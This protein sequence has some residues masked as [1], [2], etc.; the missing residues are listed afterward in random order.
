MSV[1]IN[2]V[3][4]SGS[5]LSMRWNGGRRMALVKTLLGIG[6]VLAAGLALTACGE[7]AQQATSGGEP[8]RAQVVTAERAERPSAVELQ[9]SVE[10]G[11][12]SAVS[13]RVMATVTSIRVE[14][15]EAVRAGQ[16]LATLDPQ[17]AQGQVAQAQGALSQAQA[18]EALAK[19]NYERYQALL[20]SQSAS[21]L[22]VDMARTAYEQ[23]RGAV[24]QARGAV[25]AASSVAGDARVTSPFAGHLAQRLVDVGDLAAPGRPLFVVQSTRGR[26]LSISVPESVMVVADLQ[27]GASVPV[28]VDARPDLGRMTGSVTERTPGADPMSHSYVVKV[29][30]PVT[31]VA[32]GASGRAWVETGRRTVVSVP[33]AAV[34]RY[35]GLDY[36]VLRDA[37][38]QTSSRVV[39]VG[40]RLDASTVEI[41]SGLNGGE[42]VLSGLQSLPPAGH[43]VEITQDTSSEERR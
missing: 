1:E 35:G 9:G 8:V 32:T 13:A 22:E 38:G 24:E 23:A 19:Q 14:V 21:Q 6:T 33:Q 17:V 7:T 42:A 18:A 40:Q 2:T 15:G 37:E 20:Q 39:T 41:L 27:V 5:F 16:L 29:A 34:I 30:L 26:R 11:S 28:Q 31:D 3:K 43:P 12:S 36:V 10:A 25:A 4:G